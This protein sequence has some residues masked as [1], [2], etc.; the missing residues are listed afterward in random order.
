[1]D[2]SQLFVEVVRLDICMIIGPAIAAVVSLCKRVA[3]IRNNPKWVAAL[4]AAAWAAY[5][6]V[7]PGAA[8]SGVDVGSLMTCFLS[9]FSLS[10]A[11]YETVIQPARKKIEDSL[12]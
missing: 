10:V 4:L 7:H 2:A 11:T 3:F 1:M 9:Q 5:Q 8:G 12:L 6:N